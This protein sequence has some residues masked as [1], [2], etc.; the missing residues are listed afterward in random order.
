MNLCVGFQMQNGENAE[1]NIKIT[2]DAHTCWV[3]TIMK[4]TREPFTG[5]WIHFR[6]MSVAGIATV[7]LETDSFLTQKMNL[8]TLLLRVSASSGSVGVCREPRMVCSISLKI[9]IIATTWC[10]AKQN[11]IIDPNCNVDW[12][13]KMQIDP[14][15]AR[16]FILRSR[17]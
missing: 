10:L 15:R 1:V 13:L 9:R 6:L 17:I 14:S 8:F 16:F 5:I 2:N 3:K 12:Y 4:S 11:W 7:L